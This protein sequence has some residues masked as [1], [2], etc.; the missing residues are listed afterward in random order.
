MNRFA[1]KLKEYRSSLASEHLETRWVLSASS[2]GEAFDSELT[3][4]TASLPQEESILNSGFQ[5]AGWETRTATTD[6]ATVSF[7]PSTSSSEFE[8][9]PGS[10]QTSELG[11]FNI[12]INPGTTLAA[13]T[14]ALDAFNR[15]AE[16]WEAFISDPITVTIDADMVDLGSSTIIGQAGSI[17]LN[18]GYN[19]IRNQVVASADSDDGILA[20]L[21]TAAQFNATLPSGI[22][23][24]GLL[25]GN[26]SALKAAGFTGLDS[27]FGATDGTI[28]FNTQ[29]SF[30]FDNGD[31]VTPG[32][33]DFE[34]VAA[35]EIG[36]VLGFTS[37]VD[38]VDALVDAGQSGS[39]SPRLLDLFRFDLGADPSSSSDFT[40]FNRGLESGVNSLFDDTVNEWQFSTGVETG[41]G[42]QASHWKDNNLTGVLIGIMDPTLSLGQ[43][44]T[45]AVPDL[46]SMDV[47]GYDINFGS[48]NQAPVL[49]TIGN[50]SVDEGSLL[51]FTATAN[52]PNIGDQLTFTLGA[53]APA[54]ASIHPTTGLFTWTPDDSFVSPVRIQIIVTDDGTPALDD[55]EIIQ[56]TVNNV[57]PTASIDGTD[58]IYRG[59]EV[60]FSLTA[61]DA[62]PVDQAATFTF[63][64]DWDG[65]LVFDEQVVGASG[66]QVAHTFTDLGSPNTRVRATDQDGSTGA[67]STLPVTVDRFVLRGDG[68]GNTDLIYGGT[69]GVDA[70]Y[71]LGTASSI[72]IFT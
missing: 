55:S 19:T 25:S 45:V 41:D 44:N 28:S 46:R 50:Q 13:N 58:E 43:I 34:T 12:V 40:T 49:S 60:T 37:I 30:D 69:A 15:A 48:A 38:T 9:D 32:T 70:V 62:S 66:V 2:I 24:S 51:S 26:K 67:V 56:V 16:Q 11:S 54:G 21:P 27:T 64:I 59:E 5:L 52:D 57:A 29:F 33:M 71:F 22:T 10:G 72:F 61:T 3:S 20:S 18:A 17:I 47:I 1:K 65:D 8:L 39:V 7:E 14:A 35:H 36:H 63:D 6:N 4:Y 31:G 68:Q 23:L 42:R 53:G